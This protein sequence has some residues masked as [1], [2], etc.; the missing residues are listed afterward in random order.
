MPAVAKIVPTYHP[1][2]EHG[3]EDKGK[4]YEEQVREMAGV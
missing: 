1:A 3:S 4:A 2:G